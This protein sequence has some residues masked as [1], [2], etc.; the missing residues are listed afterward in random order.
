[1]L[2]IK[3]RKVVYDPEKIIESKKK[4]E[5]KIRN[6]ELKKQKQAENNIN[7]TN[8]NRKNKK[9]N[10][11]NNVVDTTK[12]EEKKKEPEKEY[13]LPT[14]MN[15]IDVKSLENTNQ[16]KKEKY[17]G[18]IEYKL[19]IVNKSAERIQELST[20]MHFRLGEGNGECIY[21]IGVEDDGT[22][23]GISEDDM[24]E[25]LKTL[26]IIATNLGVELNI[27]YWGK[28]KIENSIICQIS[29]TKKL[30]E[31]MKVFPKKEIKI[32]FL[33]ESDTGKSTLVK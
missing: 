20:Q 3:G 13:K 27:F 21:V 32:G 8:P 11:N 26:E 18:N 1:M 16:L 31:K 19:K 24:R 22:P 15:E 12:R 28:G 33:G 4:K 2:Y 5:E 7:N 25:S 29:G 17:Y 10:M 30:D 9:N 6:I 23:R 14:L